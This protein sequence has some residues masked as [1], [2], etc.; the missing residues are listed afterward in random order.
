MNPADSI[1]IVP[2]TTLET[3]FRPAQYE[4]LSYQRGKMGVAA[5]PGSGKTFTLT[6]LTAALIKRLSERKDA[7]QVEVLIVT[8]TNVAVNSFK[9]R[10]SDILKQRRVLLPYVGYRVRTLHGLAHDILRE[11]PSLAGLSEDFLIVDERAASA[12][13]ADV[14]GVWW[15]ANSERFIAAYVAESMA[16]KSGYLNENLPDLTQ[17][18]AS[19]FIRSAKD[20]QLSPDDLRGELTHY[21]TE[22]PLA[23]FGVEVYELYQRALS[24]RGAVDFDDLGRLA[25]NALRSD[26][27]FCRRLQR[28]WPYILEDEAQDSSL[29]QQEMLNLLSGGKNWV[30]VG[31]PNQAINTTFTTAN[32][33]SLR[34]FLEDPSVKTHSLIEAGRSAS[35]IIELANYLAQWASE[36]PEAPALNA[37]L[38]PQII[39]PTRPGDMQPNPPA[40]AAQIYIGYKPGEAL[41][42][43]AELK[44]VAD[45]LVRWLPDHGH[46]T[47]A[48]LVPENARGFRLVELLRERKIAYEELLSSTTSTRAAAEK[49][50]HVLGYLA[51]PVSNRFMTLGRLYEEVWWPLHFGLDPE[52]APE[53]DVPDTRLATA[54]AALAAYPNAETFLWPDA[55]DVAAKLPIDVPSLLADVEAFRDHLRRWLGAVVLPIDQLVLTINQDLFRAPSDIALGYKFASLLRSA[56][57]RNPGWRLPE[58]VEELR[59]ISEN[60]RKFFGIEGEEIG[61]Q[62]MPGRVTVSTYHAAKGLEWDRVYLTGVSNYVFPMLQG[63]DTYLG[64]KRFLRNELNLEAEA[65]AQLEAVHGGSAYTEGKATL[66]G[67]T[68]FAAE[69]LRLLY[70]GIT[71]ARRELCITW[72]TGRFASNGT[73]NQPALPLIALSQFMAERGRT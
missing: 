42:S 34:A 44:F 50:H 56:A 14:V 16:G 31:D 69:R 33:A 17:R 40:T 38:T 55:A 7:D 61:Y 35:P 32:P 57:R 68:E 26:E 54:I 15:R 73:A 67:R 8:Y 30:R 65:L 24:G 64:E 39:K 60:E 47:V 48:V 19:R 2:T 28:R 70:V 4:I 62:P 58:F 20:R 6:H 72:N 12:I 1:Q 66:A 51:A 21:G 45:S 10:L 53:T 5:V 22:L 37:A 63:Y 23:R 71:R 52:P 9:R 49:L 27:A 13:L 41:S 43:D 11:R 25:L 46:D 18:I 36:Q 59:V 3:L 29:L